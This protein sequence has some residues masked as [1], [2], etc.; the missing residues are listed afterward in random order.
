MK[1]TE[2]FDPQKFDLT[3]K[4]KHLTPTVRES[5]K[6]PEKLSEK[7]VET[8]QG[9]QLTE[10]ENSVKEIDNAYRNLDTNHQ[11]F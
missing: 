7:Q 10:L 11:N 2:G 9:G 6:H 5:Y 8:V 3:A 4:R 1:E